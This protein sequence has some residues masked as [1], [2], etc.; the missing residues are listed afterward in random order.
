MKV[1]NQKES[2]RS[3]FRKNKTTEHPAYIFAKI[4]NKYKYI[5]LT[6]SEITDGV[7]NIKL[8]KNPNPKDKSTAYARTKT[9]Q[10]RTNDFKQKEKAWK[11]SKS[12]KEE[13]NKIIKKN[14]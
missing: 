4:G 13:I 3:E 1:K 2:K 12:D 9:E 10:A 7:R 8:D 6:H 5:G 11:F 14:N